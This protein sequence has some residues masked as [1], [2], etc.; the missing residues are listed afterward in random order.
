[1]ASIDSSG[2][3]VVRDFQDE[4]VSTSR[5]RVGRKRVSLRVTV[6]LT[7]QGTATNTIPASAFGLSR[8]LT[9]SNFVK[10]D[11][12]VIV[13]AVPNVAGTVLLLC[14]VTNA[15][16]ATRA[17]PADFTGDFTGTVEGYV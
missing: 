4:G 16:D 17:A 6:T 12:A 2:V 15:T 3:V 11:D 14:A 9:A 7:G 5:R 13:P 1:M 10:S 8:I